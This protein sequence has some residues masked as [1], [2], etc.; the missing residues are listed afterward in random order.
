MTAPDAAA[1]QRLAVR[2]LQALMASH[3]YPDPATI[4]SERTIWHGISGQIHA[5]RVCS[6]FSAGTVVMTSPEIRQIVSEVYAGP[7]QL[8]QEWTQTRRQDFIETEAAKISYQVA[9]LAAEKGAQAVGEWT[10]T[11]GQDP[12]YLTKVG[13]L[14]TARTQA[15]EIVLNNELY[16]QIPEQ[17]DQPLDLWG[18]Q[19]QPPPDRSQVPWDQ[20]WTSPPYR[21]DPSPTIEALIADLWPDPQFSAVFRIKAG[22]L[23]A[24]RHEDQLPLPSHQADPLAHELAQMVFNDLRDDGLPER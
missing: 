10:R 16:E 23:L 14:N 11:H 7:L 9:E 3:G 15:M 18:E 8:P 24:A 21:S 19:D 12:D 4:R 6:T 2:R 20:R 22:Y 17:E 5:S 13:L 1:R